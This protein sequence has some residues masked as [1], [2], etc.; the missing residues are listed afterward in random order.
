MGP[1]Y[2][3][4]V[5]TLGKV[6]R[7]EAAGQLGVAVLLKGSGGTHRGHCSSGHV[8][9]RG[10]HSVSCSFCSILI[11]PNFWVTVEEN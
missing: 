6:C 3:Q 4:T 2:I 7:E 5:Q 9:S 11:G 10:V 8:L 1:S